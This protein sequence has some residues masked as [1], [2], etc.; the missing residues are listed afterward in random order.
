MTSGVLPVASRAL[1]GACR[2][3]GIDPATLLERA[4]LSAASLDDPDGRIPAAAA[5]AV[6]QA[7]FSAAG[8]PALALH[9]AEQ[10]PF[11]AFRVLDYLAASGATLGDGIARVAAYFPLVDP[12]GALAVED[13]GGDR[14][15]VTFTST[16]GSRLPPPAQEYTL[17]ILAGRVRHLLSPDWRPAEVHLAFPRPADVR[18]HGRV[19]GAAPRFDA[20]VASL[21]L[22]RMDWERPTSSSDP[23]LFAALDEHARRLLERAEAAP[24]PD[25]VR[26]AIAAD[27]PGREPSLAAVARRVALS[28]RSVQRRLADAGTSF[29]QAVDAV[30]EE[31]AQ[32]FLR[33]GDVSLAEVSWLLGFSEQSAFTRA[34]R[35]WTGLSPTEW[36][37]KGSSGRP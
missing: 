29:A 17:A 36:R 30:R 23:S 15:T 35:R 7:A 3:L 14:V 37:R 9:A 12:R 24:L 22:S 21:A 33:S 28:P 27:L 19:L 13:R 26:A 6:W 2:R 20:E 32:A 4:G 31:R 34:F 5:D 25:R 11:G 1:V 18:E 10:T 8:D 16:V